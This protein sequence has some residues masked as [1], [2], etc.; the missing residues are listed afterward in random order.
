[1]KTFKSNDELKAL[2]KNGVLE[3]T[4]SVTC[5]FSI[6]VEA[7]IKS[8]GDITAE[9]ITAWSITARDITARSITARNIT[10]RDITA[11]DITAWSITARNISFYAVCFA[12]ISLKCKSIL[13]RRSKHQFGCLDKEIEYIKDEPKQPSLSGKKVSV[14]IDNQTYT[15]TID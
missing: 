11:R 9:N 8:A 12:Y 14:T 4:E 13:G 2:I 6:N 3:F 7:H 1:M 5:G 15:A 10:A